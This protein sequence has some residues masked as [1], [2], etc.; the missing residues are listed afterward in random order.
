MKI[1]FG[2]GNPG[3]KYEL[4]RHNI[5]FQVIDSLANQLHFPIWEKT[6]KFQA[7]LSEKIFNEERIILVKPQT[8]MNNS[9][10]SVS[11]IINFYK[12][13][14][15]KLLIIHDDSDLP[16]GKVKIRVNSEGKNTHNGLR[17][18]I[19]SLGTPLFTRLRLGVGNNPDKPLESYILEEFSKEERQKLSGF[20]NIATEIVKDWLEEEKR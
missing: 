8:F 17:S 13:S 1:V 20:L 6:S 16:F 4:T 19:S 9:G 11:K 7:V 10:L 15:K 3:Q 18:I 5:G 2:L 14:S 12:I